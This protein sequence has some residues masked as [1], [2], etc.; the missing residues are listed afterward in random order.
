MYNFKT[1]KNNL[2]WT[3]GF[4]KLNF[5]SHS[6]RQLKQLD[7]NKYK[8]ISILKKHLKEDIIDAKPETDGGSNSEIYYFHKPFS[9][10]YQVGQKKS[11]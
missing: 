8:Q 3:D 2:C 11:E 4:K 10:Y 6:K 7:Q 5:N 9:Y 1:C